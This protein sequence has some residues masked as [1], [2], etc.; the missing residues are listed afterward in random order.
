MDGK[1][2]IRVG[3]KLGIHQKYLESRFDT[4]FND[5]NLLNIKLQKEQDELKKVQDHTKEAQDQMKETI[6]LLKG[7]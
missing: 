6:D 5:L 4:K 7:V 3:L 2:D 1:I